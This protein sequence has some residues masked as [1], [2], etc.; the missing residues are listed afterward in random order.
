MRFDPTVVHRYRIDCH[1]KGLKQMVDQIS[2]T[3]MFE[4]ALSRSFLHA[5]RP[6]IYHEFQSRTFIDLYNLCVEEFQESNFL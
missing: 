4:P 5:H 1:L 3:M 6:R 2:E